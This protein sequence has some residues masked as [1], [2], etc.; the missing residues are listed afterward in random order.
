MEGLFKKRRLLLALIIAG[1]AAS[2]ILAALTRSRLSSRPKITDTEIRTKLLARV[3]RNK[4]LEGYEPSPSALYSNLLYDFEL[5]RSVA[6]TLPWAAQVPKD[7]YG[8]Y[9][10][11]WRMRVTSSG[12]FSMDAPAGVKGPYSVEII[13]RTGGPVYLRTDDIVLPDERVEL[14]P[15]IYALKITSS[16]PLDS[17][18]AEFMADGTTGDVRTERGAPA[19][20]RT[21]HLQLGPAAETELKRLVHLALDSPG[22]NV[23]NIPKGRVRGRLF[24]GDDERSAVEARIGLSGRTRV[25]MMRF[26]S[27]DVKVSGGK[28]LMGTAGFKLYRLNT[29]SGFYEMTL[30]SVLSDMGFL[31]PRSE[32]VS[33]YVNDEPVGIYMFMETNTPALFTS[34]RKA[35]GGIIGVDSDKMFFDYPYG[36]EL[37]RRYFYS[38]KGPQYKKKSARF[39]FSRDFTKRLER[40]STA[41]YMAFTAPYLSTHGLGID[42][43]RFYEDPSTG[44]FSP[45]PRDLDPPDISGIKNF[46]LYPTSMSWSASSPVYTLWPIK[47]PLNAAVPMRAWPRSSDGQAT[48]FVT[49][50]HF[51]LSSF[52]ADPENLEATNR[53]LSYFS[54]NLA[55]KQQLEARALNA[56]RAAY[57][58]Y[59]DNAIL[60]KQTGEISR[61]G[62][63]Y[64]GKEI[65]LHLLE[66]GLTFSDN[67]NT[68]YWNIRTAKEL[69]RGLMPS[70]VAPL[71]DKLK[72]V[73]AKEAQYALS[74]EMER[75]VFG[76]LEE[77]G[78]A[79]GRRTFKKVG[80]VTVVPPGTIRLSGSAMR[81]ADS[82]SETGV[83]RVLNNVVT[84]LAT[85]DTDGERALIL[86]LVRN[87]TEDASDFALSPRDGVMSYSPSLNKTFVLDSAGPQRWADIK[88]IF[89][90]HFFGGERMRLVAFEVPM[91]KKALFYRLALPEKSWIFY[92]P[93]MYIPARSS[94]AEA[95]GSTLATA[96]LPEG[97]VERVDGI[98]VDA[99]A[100]ITLAGQVTIPPGKALYVHHGATIEG[101]AKSSL[102][103]TG[104]LYLLGTPESP[105]RFISKTEAPW[106]GLYAA[107]EVNKKIKVVVNNTRFENYGAY[108]LTRF[109]RLKL[110]GGLSFLNARVE[111]D[112]VSIRDAHS[113]D[114]VN[115][116]SSVA[117]IKDTVI[118]GAY[119]DSVDLDFSYAKISGLDVT[120]TKG[121]ALDLSFSL[122]ECTGC[123]FAGSGDKGISAG[124]MSRVFVSDSLFS[125]NDMG[126]ADK[127]QSFVSVT[128]SRFEGNRI[129]VA[130]FI[131]KPY[132]G[133]PSSV[134]QENS[135]VDNAQDYAW[136]GIFMY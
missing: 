35:E 67:K 50:I 135:Y 38:P 37:G 12:H 97:F 42:D 120:G 54:S 99:N 93:M 23:I 92:P 68:W 6:G 116:V 77:A 20:L 108:P 61:N 119:S 39:F 115:I 118:T 65:R 2:S 45:M 44:D 126:I 29:K 30:L 22:K 109:G 43:L 110:S 75:R 84:H 71:L 88:S 103:L 83:N 70:L 55:L 94:P 19:A 111:F 14:T 123:R 24:E 132:F 9:S 78:I 117:L 11:T 100:H 66:K 33:L 5:S 46:F 52:I 49:D 10:F 86:F 13:K 53:Y 107:G 31:V 40:K 17:F 131:K 124:E 98:H 1:I 73:E 101:V 63:P 133:R 27:I 105:I 102:Q 48:V 7:P 41:R 125:G 32:A 114:A 95:L 72:S 136:L 36:G 104:D 106:G 21:I 90:N 69:D 85:L 56:L 4:D 60:T 121:D 130:E 26:P 16:T 74:F 34:R 127:D 51:A 8:E 58:A 134:I 96:P 64:L 15:G 91:S 82:F 81:G 57:K 18:R 128:G 25:H 80:P 76:L 122:V 47:R 129:A 89:S 79:P 112:H 113:E 62:F 3:E 28:S 87:A 59:P